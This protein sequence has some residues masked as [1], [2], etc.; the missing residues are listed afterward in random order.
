MRLWL[1]VEPH[2]MIDE[3]LFPIFPLPALRVVEATRYV[4]PLREGGSLP[5]IVE[6]N[7]DG[8]YVLKF[9]G[10]GQGS[11]ALI[12]ELVGGEIA[13]ALGLRVPEIVFVEVEAILGRS[14]P[15]WEIQELIVGSAGLNLALDFLPGALGFDPL[16]KPPP[17][18]ELASAIVW[19][20]ALISNVDRTPRNPNMILWHDALWLI[21]HGASLYFQHTWDGS[22]PDAILA[23]SR[24][25]FAP[26]RDHV[27]LPGASLLAEVDPLLAARLTPDVLRAIVELI[28]ETWLDEKTG[29]A[30]PQAHRAAYLGYLLSRLAPPRPWVEEAI[31]AH[32][33]LV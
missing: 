17:A 1:R 6:A 9:R 14:E 10:A 19:L 26:I 27:L 16:A 5:A 25:A 3:S 12:A 2:A 11:K 31:R 15:D 24:S 23:R 7:D 18:P 21:D 22:A 4:T 13:R 20:D 32:A 29:F 30:T 28:P 33:Q 8:L